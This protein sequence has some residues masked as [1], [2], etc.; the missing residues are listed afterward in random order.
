MI[1]DPVEEVKTPTIPIIKSVHFKEITAV[2]PADVGFQP[3]KSSRSTDNIAGTAVVKPIPRYADTPFSKSQQDLRIG[4]PEFGLN[5]LNRSYKSSDDLLL[6]DID[7]LR[8]KP[9]SRQRS[10]RWKGRSQENLIIASAEDLSTAEKRTI[11]KPLPL[12]RTNS[13][14]AVD[15]GG[16]AAVVTEMRVKPIRVEAATSRPLTVTYVYSSEKDEF[17]LSNAAAA[18]RNVDKNNRTIMMTKERHSMDNI[19]STKRDSNVIRREGCK[20]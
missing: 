10:K 3:I 13:F 2:L 7:G 20:Y 15:D 14:D 17:V 11:K 12:P 19:F 5:S 8:R 6:D 4:E 1:L 9:T 16:G 18:E